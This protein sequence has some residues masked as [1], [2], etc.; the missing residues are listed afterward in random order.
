MAAERKVYVVCGRRPWNRRVF[1]ERICRLPGR[2]VFL[3]SPS[4]LTLARLRRLKPRF[5]F[6]LHWSWRVP[7][8]IFSRY[9]CVVFHM[10]DVPYGR[11]GSPLQN[12]ILRNHRTTRLSAI[13]MEEELDAG[14]VYL[15]RVLSLKGGAQ[16]VYER[17]TEVS[18][19]MIREIVERL[20]TPRVQGGRIVRFRRRTPAESRIGNLRRPERLYDF[21]RMLDADGYPHAFLDHGGFRY[22]FRNARRTRQGLAADVRIFPIGK[23]EKRGV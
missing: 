6:F 17:A 5:V 10:T 21:I 18:A 13:R 3:A 22:T 12:L 7:K 2:W 16:E 9:E 19:R 11:G 4:Q 14:S 23:G 20:P 15:K 1:N 8:E